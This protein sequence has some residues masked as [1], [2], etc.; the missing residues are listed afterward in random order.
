MA[1]FSDVLGPAPNNG[2]ASSGGTDEY[3]PDLSIVMKQNLDN[4]RAAFSVGNLNVQSTLP[5][6]VVI[7]AIEVKGFTQARCKGEEVCTDYSTLAPRMLLEPPRRHASNTGWYCDP[8]DHDDGA[9][10]RLKEGCSCK[11]RNVESYQVTIYVKTTEKDD[12]T[13]DHVF[14]ICMECRVIEL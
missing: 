12:T 14:K 8:R 1:E 9:L 6:S 5:K 13:Q 10:E 4:D 3:F 2:Y 7:E 11:T